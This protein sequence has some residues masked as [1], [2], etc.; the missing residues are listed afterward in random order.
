ME[1]PEQDPDDERGC[2]ISEEGTANEEQYNE[3][4]LVLKLKQAAAMM[5]LLQKSNLI[6]T[7]VT[8]TLTPT[9][10]AGV[11]WSF[12]RPTPRS[13]KPGL[14]EVGCSEEVVRMVQKSIW[15][16]NAS[17]TTLKR[18]EISVLL[19]ANVDTSVIC[20]I[21]NC[22]PNTVYRVRRLKKKDKI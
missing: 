2:T 12:Y 4:I 20:W 5:S 1:E 11:F 3:C 10:N 21:T 17:K 13:W 8:S 18:Q 16:G 22:S 19:D 14:K 9:V 15:E 6:L 7:L